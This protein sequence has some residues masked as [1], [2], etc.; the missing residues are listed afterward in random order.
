MWA[1]WREL[2]ARGFRC[3]PRWSFSGGSPGLSG[4]ASCLGV[5]RLD[6]SVTAGSEASLARRAVRSCYSAESDLSFSPEA[7]DNP[8]ADPEEGMSHSASRY[9]SGHMRLLLSDGVGCL[10]FHRR[11]AR[12]TLPHA[13]C[14]ELNVVAVILVLLCKIEILRHT[15]NYKTGKLIHKASSS[16]CLYPVKLIPLYNS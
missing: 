10:C 12:A 1:V 6:A 2:G 5:C 9:L 13:F 8:A 7:D 3:S 11:T 4:Y 16:V 15:W 14:F